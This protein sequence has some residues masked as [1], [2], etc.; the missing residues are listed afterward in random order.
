MSTDQL[1]AGDDRDQSDTVVVRLTSDPDGVVV[2]LRVRG[3]WNR[4]LFVAVR[5]AVLKCLVEHPAAVILD[6]RAVQDA[7]AS[8]ASL[9]FAL[10]RTAEGMQPPVGMAVCV[11]PQTPLAVRL[12]RLGA[13]QFLPVF[14]TVAQAR[15]ALAAGSAIPQQLQRR[16]P[17]APHAADQATAVVADA[18]QAWSL[19][20]LVAPARLVIRELV[21]NA[22]QHAG[23]DILL[24]VARR[25]D[26]L[27][28]AVRDG[29]LV[30]PR[31]LRP[32]PVQ[33]GAPV[34]R[35]QGLLAVDAVA[36]AW[37]ARPTDD[38]TGKVVWVTL[39]A[40]GTTAH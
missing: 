36:S 13:R 30:L 20:Q 29:S 2:Q 5:A 25:D 33:P 31:R 24:T 32:A 14:A 17:A 11:Q 40:C 10:R 39:R 4:R 3:C 16:L 26:A 12:D 1:P 19:P 37:G 18:C 21:T 15:T 6:L 7:T 28:L 23:T 34:Q 8:S 22:I 38:G 27:Y 9:W 35:G